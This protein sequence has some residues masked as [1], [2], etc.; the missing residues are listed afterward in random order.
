MMIGSSNDAE[1]V[2]TQY[3]TSNGLNTR[4]AFHDMYSTNKYGYGNWILSNYE[5]SEGAKVLEVGCGTAKMWVGHDDLIAKC[6]LLTLTDMSEGMLSTARENIG[7]RKNVAYA[8]ADIQD[9]PFEDDSFDAVIANSML[10]HVPNIECGIREVRRVLRNKGVFYCATYG[11]N[12]FTDVL[13]DWF[14]LDGESF[15]PNHNFTMQNGEQKLKEVFTN[16]EANFYEDSLHITNIEDLTD[17]LRSLV[18]LKAIIDLPSDR[19]HEILM[20]HS[21]NGTIELPKE[22]GMFVCR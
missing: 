1:S 6:E 8:L 16:V 21:C 14:E 22:Y 19:I 20:R 15:R 9:I 4:I 5:I 13:A 12:N 10:Y 7:E 3:S 11:E 2:R 18:S 17:Y